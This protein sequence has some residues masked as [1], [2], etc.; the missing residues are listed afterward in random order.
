MLRG[1]FETP[2][3]LVIPNNVTTFGAQTVLEMAIRNASADFYVG[4]CNAVFEPDLTVADI[5]EPTPGLNG[6][7][8][9]AVTRD[10]TGWPTIGELNGERFVQTDW[11]TWAAVGSPFDQA[12]SRMFIVCDNVAA[13]APIFA[14][15][16]VL[17]EERII[18]PLTAEGDRRFK[19]TLFLR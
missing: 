6:Y 15:S 11:L 8:R 4:L 3:G 17:P 13:D 5:E 12:I 18:T 1:Q 16:A 7:A 19:Y 2:S 9:I 14:L 10:N